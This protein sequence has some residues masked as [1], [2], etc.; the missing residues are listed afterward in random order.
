[1]RFKGIAKFGC[2]LI[3][4]RDDAFDIA[5][6]LN[7]LRGGFVANPGNTRKIIGGLA[8]EG[9]KVEPLVRGDTVA[10]DN[11]SCVI[12]DDIGDSAASHDHGHPI[13]DKLENVSVTGDDDYFTAFTTAIPGQS[14]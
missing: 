11:C 6:L 2:K 9:D 7:E 4:M 10:V 1:M 12:T 14:C 13:A 8:L 5:I 3:R